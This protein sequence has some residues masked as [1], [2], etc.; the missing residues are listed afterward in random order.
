MLAA[1]QLLVLAYPQ[2]IVARSTHDVDV[3]WSGEILMRQA[4]QPGSVMPMR[5]AYVTW[6]HV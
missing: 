3:R 5:S 1:A 2:G 4:D 6:V